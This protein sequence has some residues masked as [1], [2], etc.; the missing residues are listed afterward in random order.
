M[1]RERV[2]NGR[3]WVGSCRFFGRVVEGIERQQ[4]GETE[5]DHAAGQPVRLRVFQG[6]DVI[7]DLYGDNARLL[8]NI[9][10]DHQDDAEFPNG[11]CK[12][13]DGAGQEP[14]PGQWNSD[15]PKGVPRRGAQRRSHFKRSFAYRFKGI[16]Y[17]LNNKGERVDDRGK[18]QSRKG[19]GEESKSERLGQ[20][21]NGPARTHE[22]EQVKTDDRRGKYERHG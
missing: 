20:M 13:K 7:V 3:G 12:A 2:G 19:K 17:G 8:R 4:Y 21:P 16:L 1:P 6:F 5:Q 18:D 14:W 11:M 10:A 15:R 22:H 9:A